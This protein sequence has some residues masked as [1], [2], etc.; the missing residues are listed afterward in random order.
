MDASAAALVA[1]RLF[2]FQSIDG[3]SLGWSSESFAVLLSSLIRL[4][5]EHQ[6]RF[7][8]Q[9]FY[10]LRLKFSP[11]EFRLQALDVYGGNLYLNPADT[12]LEWLEAFQEVTEERLEQ[13]TINRTLMEQR[14]ACLQEKFGIKLR[15]GYSCSSMEY[16]LFLHQMVEP[17]RPLS[18]LTTKTVRSSS[19]EI[20]PSSF[21]SSIQTERVQLVVETPVACRRPKV[22]REGTIRIPSNI[23]LSDLA[24]A[25]SKLSDPARSRF[26]WEK[27][28]QEKCREVIREVQWKL[29][30]QKV[31]RTGVVHHEEFLGALSRMIEQSSEL[32]GK[33]SG[34]SLGVASRGQFCSVADDG[35]L[36]VPHNWT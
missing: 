4:H 7:H 32:G 8:V 24:S 17:F 23:T 3:I 21:P 1:R 34:Y 29:G 20:V 25:V 6:H 36:I 19:T 30:I 16:H 18:S 31:F 33:L 35:S 5:E 12:Q 14:V 15:K 9:S 2:S 10:P 13:Y 11:D 27:T 22:T 28:Q 26:D